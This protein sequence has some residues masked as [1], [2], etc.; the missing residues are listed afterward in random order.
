MRPVHGGL[1]ILLLLGACATLEKPVEEPTDAAD[2]PL[3]FDAP[4]LY[5]PRGVYKRFHDARGLVVD[6]MSMSTPTALAAFRYDRISGY[7]YLVPPDPQEV[8]EGLVKETMDWDASGELKNGAETTRYR[9]FTRKEGT[10]IHCVALQRSVKEHTEA[11]AGLF[12]QGLITGFYCRPT[13][14]T[15]AD[16]PAISAALRVK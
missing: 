7:Y 1:T 11:P 5:A 12:S 2:S 9:L 10:R 6:L 13:D 8:V 3:R 4:G 14:L 15:D 16:V